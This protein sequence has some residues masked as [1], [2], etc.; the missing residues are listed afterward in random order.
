MRFL[1]PLLVT[2]AACVPPDERPPRELRVVTLVPAATEII[3]A[4]GQTAVLVGRAEEDSARSVAHLPSVGRIL[5]PSVERIVDLR[6]QLVIA[7]PGADPVLQHMRA[8][9]V[10]TFA[11][12][13]DRVNDVAVNTREI[14]RLLG[15]AQRAD[16]LAQR[17]TS[18]LA[19]LRRQHAEDR[20]PA[21]LYLLDTEP[22]WTSGASTFIDDL[23]GIAG[24]TNVFT[25]LP[26]QWSQVSMESVVA[27]QPDVIIVAQ[28]PR[29]AEARDWLQERGWRQLP[30]VRSGRVYFVDA[31][32]FNSP[33]P[34]VVE[35]ARQLA[36]LLQPGSHR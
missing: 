36:N 13:F 31:D 9:G 6:P 22:Y 35:T 21:V 25:D 17:I 11:A 29:R 15:V 14:G 20:R 33:G 19:Q 26:V 10:R 32:H 8:L 12:R 7:W 16:S 3:V 28:P 5:T 34:D 2:L 24:G 1:W 30:A 23:I 27:R 4:L 18:E